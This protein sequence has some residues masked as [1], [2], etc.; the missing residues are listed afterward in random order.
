MCL[1]LAA[2]P[3]LGG[4]C[5][6]SYR[7]TGQQ[8]ECQLIRAFEMHLRSFNGA[9]VLRNISWEGEGVVKAS[10]EVSGMYSPVQPPALHSS[11]LS[12][13]ANW[14][15]WQ[16][17]T[18]ILS[19]ATPKVIVVSELRDKQAAVYWGDCL[20]NSMQSQWFRKQ[21]TCLASPCCQGAEH[22]PLQTP[23]AGGSVSPWLSPAES[24]PSEEEKRVSACAA[25]HSG[26]IV[27]VMAVSISGLTY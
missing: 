16:C 24:I 13:A 9:V 26:P 5:C 14:P 23:K 17:F 1:A 21:L 10:S 7:D 25:S 11:G 2:K 22:T 20:Q 3:A 12:H 4:Q 15:H 19:F 6:I 27:N 8:P 18:A